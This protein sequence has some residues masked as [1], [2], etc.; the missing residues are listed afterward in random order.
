MPVR[1]IAFEGETRDDL[2][3]SFPESE[4]TRIKVGQLGHMLKAIKKFGAGYS[5]MVG[6]ITPPVGITL[7]I[8]TEITRLPMARIFKAMIP[9]VMAMIVALLVVTFWPDMVLLVPRLLGYQG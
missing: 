6:Q 3:E 4:R 9:Y 7:Y 2:Y 5:I 1:L 8:V